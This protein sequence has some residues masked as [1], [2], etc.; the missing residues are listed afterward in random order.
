MHTQ[1]KRGHSTTKGHRRSTTTA[2]KIKVG[3]KPRKSA[4]SQSNADDESSLTSKPAQ[5]TNL[6]T[7]EE[8]RL[9]QSG[10][11]AVAQFNKDVA[12]HRDDWLTITGPALLIVR[13]APMLCHR[14]FDSLNWA[15]PD[16]L[17]SRLG[18]EYCGFLCKRIDAST[19]LCGRFLDDNKL[20]ESGHKE[21]S[22][23]L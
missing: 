11:A 5:P 20:C 6:Y 23:F 17:P 2:P 3:L 4:T 12:R 19:L 18:L 14:V 22:R 16:N 1:T 8:W 13:A 9:C 21:G 10:V 15:S 7:D